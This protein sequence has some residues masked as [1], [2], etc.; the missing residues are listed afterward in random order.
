MKKLYLSLAL[1]AAMASGANAQG[2][3]GVLSFYGLQDYQ[4]LHISPNGKWAVGIFTN[5]YSDGYGFRWN[6]ETNECKLLSSNTSVSTAYC[7]ADD[8]TVA[9]EFSDFTLSPNGA[10]VTNIGYYKG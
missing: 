6:L 8:G 5:G 1:F 10:P 2:D 7:V 9:G 3:T 4:V